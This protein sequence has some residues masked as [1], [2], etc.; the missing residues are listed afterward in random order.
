MNAVTPYNF[1]A[2]RAG[3]Y[4]GN[5]MLNDLLA[6]RDGPQAERAR[7]VHQALCALGIRHET[8]AGFATVIT[9]VLATGVAHLPNIKEVDQ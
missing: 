2:E 6:Q 8:A 7:T 4:I 9:D 3:A 1:A 5:A